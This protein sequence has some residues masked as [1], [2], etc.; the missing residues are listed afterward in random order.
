MSEAPSFL[1]SEEERTEDFESSFL[2]QLLLEK[3]SSIN[4]TPMSAFENSATSLD[5]AREAKPKRLYNGSAVDDRLGP[6]DTL[7]ATNLPN[8]GQN[9]EALDSLSPLINEGRF[10]PAASPQLS[11]RSLSPQL[12]VATEGSRATRAGRHSL[13]ETRASYSHGPESHG[14][15]SHT[16]SSHARTI[17]PATAPT[18]RLPRETLQPYPSSSS[19]VAPPVLRSLSDSSSIR[20]VAERR[21]GLANGHGNGLTPGRRIS[22]TASN[23]AGSSGGGSDDAGWIT[24]KTSIGEHLT[25][26]RSVSPALNGYRPDVGRRSSAA[27]VATEYFD[28]R[29]SVATLSRQST[30]HSHSRRPASYASSGGTDTGLGFQQARTTYLRHTMGPQHSASQAN[31]WFD[32][33]PKVGR[34]RPNIPQD[35]RPSQRNGQSHPV[36]HRR[37]A[38][39]YSAA[40]SAYS[41]DTFNPST[42]VSLAEAKRS[43]KID[44]FLR[45][46]KAESSLQAITTQSQIEKEAFLDALQESR[47]A[48]E[49]LRAQ[50]AELMELLDTAR[51]GNAQRQA[52]S[53][54]ETSR[55]LAEVV[56]ARDN[57]QARAQDAERRLNTLQQEHRK[58]V[59]QT[60]ALMSTL[61]KELT[62]LREQLANAR[63]EKK[64]SSPR[65]SALPRAK[66]DSPRASSV[67]YAKKTEIPSSAPKVPRSSDGLPTIKPSNIVPRSRNVSSGTTT[68]SNGVS[69]GH[70]RAMSSASSLIYT[71]FGDHLPPVSDRWSMVGSTEASLRLDDSTARYLEDFGDITTRTRHDSSGTT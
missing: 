20:P 5:P 47:G 19:Q 31:L 15:E 70:G 24:P 4:E 1:I 65:G 9:D 27:T 16:S 28:D 54:Q 51:V 41:G 67:T 6:A 44:L 66:N 63:V 49:H 11:P 36:P 53:D 23:S 10:S 55:Q 48:L 13:D 61:R 60:N 35:F 22:T 8:G 56:D 40:S 14:P 2:R 42:T 29:G 71:D 52:H 45:C 57:W 46:T 25:R 59:E 34:A 33:T 26:R 37:E 21:T 3:E 69:S 12:P 17:S 30:A 64:A 38:S 32:D 58:E 18:G 7:A 68:S 50:N 39:G 43:D 62:K